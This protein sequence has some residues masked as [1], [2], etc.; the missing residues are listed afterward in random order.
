MH[1]FHHVLSGELVVVVQCASV[2]GH[3]GGLAILGER[4]RP[5][6]HDAVDVV[7]DIVVVDSFLGK[8]IFLTIF[9]VVPYYFDEVISVTARLLMINT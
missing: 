2:L 9:N 1:Q 8:L 5:I 6:L 4:C 7:L 3:H